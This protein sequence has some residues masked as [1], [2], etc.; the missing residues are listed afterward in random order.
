M[1]SFETSLTGATRID[2]DDSFF[3]KLSKYMRKGLMYF[4]IFILLTMNLVSVSVALQCNRE[5]S[6]ILKIASGVYAFFFGIIYIFIN[7]SYYRIGVKG[8]TT[9]CFFCA[10]KIFPF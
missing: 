9:T 10:D 1:S 6:I 7:Y 3:D 8:D 4:L 5:K 2:E